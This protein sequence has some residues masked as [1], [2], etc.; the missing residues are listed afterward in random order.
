VV[1]IGVDRVHVAASR[2][3]VAVCGLVRAS[4]GR[5]SVAVCGLGSCG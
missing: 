4:D 5:N 3:S 2:N 1:W